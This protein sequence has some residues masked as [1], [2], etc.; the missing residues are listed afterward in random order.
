MICVVDMQITKRL[1]DVFTFGLNEILKSLL[2]QV[3]NRF[4]CLLKGFNGHWNFTPLICVALL[5]VVK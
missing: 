3:S 5:L 1:F 4:A 2:F